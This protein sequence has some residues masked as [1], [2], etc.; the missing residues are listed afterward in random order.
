M[1]SA[2]AIYKISLALKAK[3]KRGK[4]NLKDMVEDLAGAKD[5][6]NALNSHGHR[7]L[8]LE[9]DKKRLNLL[10]KL[11]Q[12]Q[13]FSQSML[14]LFTDILR[15]EFDWQNYCDSDGTI[16]EVKV[17]QPVQ[18]FEYQRLLAQLEEADSHKR[19]GDAEL[20]SLLGGS[21]RS[22]G[23][24]RRSTRLEEEEQPELSLEEALQKLDDMV[25]LEELKAETKRVVDYIGR[26]RAS[27]RQVPA[28][29][30][31]PFHYICTTE[32]SGVGLSTA[33]KLLS[34]IFYHLEICTLNGYAEEAVDRLNG[35]LIDH[36]FDENGLCAALDINR[37]DEFELEEL[38]GKLCGEYSNQVVM[39]VLDAEHK[40]DLEA[41]KLKMNRHGVPYRNLHLKAYSERELIE[42]FKKLIE[43]YGFELDAEREKVLQK[44]IARLKNADSFCG[45]RTMQEISCKMAFELTGREAG[46]EEIGEFLISYD[47]DKISGASNRDHGAGTSLAELDSLVGLSEVKERVREIL[48]HFSVE[49]KKCDLN[50]KGAQLCMH[51]IFSGNPGTGKTTVA[52]I[53]GQILKE[54]GVLGKGDLIEACR[55]DLVARY[56]GHT[57]LKTAA[58]VEKSLGSVLFIDEAY[59]LDGSSE[60]DFG[61]EALSTLVKKM[62]EHKDELVVIMA[63]YRDEMEKMVALN[64]GLLS[65]VPHKIDF[66]DYSGNELYMIY[67]QLLGPDY[68]ISDGAEKKL[69]ELFNKAAAASN[70]DGGNG[71]FVRNAVERL[72]MK[73]GS[74]LLRDDF[75]DR[76]DM[77]HINE[78]DVDNL[79]KDSDI[80]RYL[81]DGG[82]SRIGFG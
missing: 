7:M 11:N 27:G 45:V 50:I 43:P 75:K 77:V 15:D 34:T 6:F 28:R 5:E 70:K 14:G 40:S 4:I 51:M 79:L 78:E 31:Y 80:K 55:E 29:E 62:E 58:L 64:P 19:L 54:E 20:E 60:I 61:R 26:L 63:G 10:L 8:L 41:L 81:V 56:V 47:Q 68:N 36:R 33:C 59:A 1:L 13:V 39:L 16:F 37:I 82:K 35:F 74:R 42:I 53:V 57:A 24:T 38:L 48:G 52:R 65:R 49:K 72:K 25:G 12:G 67:E 2:E 69:R 23:S 21:A 3:D 73:Q 44:V 30:A 71:R 46:N 17:A 32:G 22:Q 76:E 66:P 9:P 18:R